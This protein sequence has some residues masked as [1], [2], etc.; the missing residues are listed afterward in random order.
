[1]SKGDR[2]Y[3]LFMSGYNCAQAVAGAFADELGMSTESVARLTSGFGGGMGRMREVCGTFSGIVMVVSWLYGYSS[4]DDNAN[5]K[6][7]YERIRSIADT[8]RA[9]NGS[10]ICRELLGIS[11]PERSAAPSERTAEYYKKRPCKELCRYAADLLEKYIAENPF[12]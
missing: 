1:M 8:F 4:P 9:D 11:E 7:V 12:H 6:A 2:A 5:K 3:E 10:I